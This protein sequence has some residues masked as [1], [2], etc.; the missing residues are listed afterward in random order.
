M[1]Y[2]KPSIGVALEK[3]RLKNLKQIIIIPLFPQYASATNGS[4]IEE[5]MEIVKNWWV[6]PEISFISQ[7]YNEKLFL[8]A[9]FKSIL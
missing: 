6:I 5:V 7:F 1:R 9:F 4:V 2:K 3:L 8:D